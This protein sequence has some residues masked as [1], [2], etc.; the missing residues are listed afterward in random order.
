MK[1]TNKQ[2]NVCQLVQL[3]NIQLFVSLFH[4]EDQEDDDDADDD[5]DD[6]GGDGEDHDVGGD[7]C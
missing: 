1:Q 4:V 2:L 3:T 5:A 7:E 6:D